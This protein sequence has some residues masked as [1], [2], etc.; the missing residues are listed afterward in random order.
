MND[1]LTIGLKEASSSLGL[2]HWTLRQYIRQ[3]RIKAVRIGRR[4]LLEPSELRR[5]VEQGRL[6]PQE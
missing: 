2:S 5:L 3:G 1:R 6:E 4:V